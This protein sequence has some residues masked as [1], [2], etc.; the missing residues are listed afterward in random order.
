MPIKG[1][2]E[3][4]KL[5]VEERVKSFSEVALGLTEEQAIEEA[6]RCL[7]CKNYPC[8]SGCPVGVDIPRF[9]KK[10]AEKNFLEA[11]RIIKEKDAIP[12]IT[13]RVCPQE[14]QCESKCTLQRVKEPIAIGALERFVADWAIREGVIREEISRAPPNGIKVAVIGSGPAGITVAADLAKLGYEVTMFEALHKPGGVLIYGIPEFRLPKRIVE[15]EIE[16]LKNIGVNIITNTIIGRTYT[17]KDLFQD[18][19]RAIFI[20]TGAGMPK[21]LNI[22]GENLVNIYTANEFLTRTNLMKAYLF[23][24]YD[25]PIKVGNKVGVIGG[26]NVAM[27][28]A[29]TSIRLGAKEVYIIY[30]RTE[31]EMPARRD[32]VINAKEEGVKLQL[33]TQ[34]IRF[35]GDRDKRLTGIECLRMRLGEPDSSGRRRPIPIEGSE[36]IFELDS[37]I[38][39]IGCHP[40][41]LIAKTTPEI[42]VNDEGCIIVDKYCRA[43]MRSVYAAGD[44]I[45]GEA[46]VIEAM[47]TGRTA[48]TTMHQDIK[49]GK[50]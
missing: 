29:R 14:V 34:P 30:R 40:N 16:Y 4:N 13:G 5:P 23:P 43:S 27:D 8:V 15:Y 7:Q 38:V 20:G 28:A 9:I 18:G 26:G 48:S 10:I 17:I 42:K 2:V 1:R 47:G 25:T 45:L 22:P 41:P 6:K 11:Y 31:E 49:S 39:A 24:K 21:F 44:I 12:A 36:F 37:A 32:E 19:F 50:I 3:M 33:L 35:V 46:T